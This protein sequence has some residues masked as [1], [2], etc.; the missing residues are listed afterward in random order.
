MPD[1]NDGDDSKARKNLWDKNH[2]KSTPSDYLSIRDHCKKEKEKSTDG[3]YVN[4]NTLSLHIEANEN[5]I[6]KGNAV[7][8]VE[9]EGLKKFFF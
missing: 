7:A 3:L 1:F 2:V 6:E 5:L 8:S 4:T 9:D